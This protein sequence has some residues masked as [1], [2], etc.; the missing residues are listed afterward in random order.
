MVDGA[1][2][3]GETSGSTGSVATGAA[4]PGAVDQALAVGSWGSDPLSIV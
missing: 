3:L 2:A 4:D 1:A